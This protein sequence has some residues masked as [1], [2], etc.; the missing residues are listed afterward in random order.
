MR[1]I[2]VLLACAATATHAQTRPEQ[3]AGDYPSR[4]LRIIVTVPAGGS[5]DSVTR[6]MAQKLSERNGVNVIVD[7]RVGGKF[8]RTSGIKL[9]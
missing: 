9:E 1:T 7:N 8:I 4:P 6:A 3:R 2:L 5:V